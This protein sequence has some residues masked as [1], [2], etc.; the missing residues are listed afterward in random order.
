MIQLAVSLDRPNRTFLQGERITGTVT[1][2]ASGVV[3]CEELVVEF[4]HHFS[5]RLG[6]GE[7]VE[8][9]T[10]LF[11]GTWAPGVHAYPFSLP[12]TAELPSYQGQL[13]T[14]TRTV[15]ARAVPAGGAPGEAIAVVWV[16]CSPRDNAWF[17]PREQ[18]PPP[19]LFVLN[20]AP[21]R[22]LALKRTMEAVAGATL[23]G[24][25]PVAI[26]ISSRVLRGGDTVTITV[27]V[28]GPAGRLT[29]LRARLRGVE[30]WPRDHGAKSRVVHSEEYAPT[31]NS[32]GEITTLRF[33]LPVP[34]DAISIAAL[35]Q[36]RIQLR[37]AYG[38]LDNRD[39]WQPLWI[40]PSE[41]SLARLRGRS[42]EE[43]AVVITDTAEQL[44][45][46][47]AGQRWRAV[48]A[49]L[50]LVVSVGIP[51]GVISFGESG[52]FRPGALGVLAGIAAVIGW[53]VWKKR[54]VDRDFRDR[55]YR[56]GAGDNPASAEIAP[57]P[58]PLV[59]DLIKLGESH[60]SPGGDDVLRREVVATQQR[61]RRR[62]A[63]GLSFLLGVNLVAALI[64]ESPPLASGLAVPLTALSVLVL[65]ASV[66]RS[67]D[68]RPL[69][70]YVGM[71]P[72]LVLCWLVVSVAGAMLTGT[73]GILGRS[74]RD[75][76]AALLLLVGAVG[77]VFAARR[78]RPSTDGGRRLLVLW[79]FGATSRMEEIMREVALQW[80]YLGPIQYLRG[81]GSRADLGRLV[82]AL[83]RGGRELFADSLPEVMAHLRRFRFTPNI[84]GIYS[85][86]SLQC[87]NAVWRDAVD[88]L[89]D[90]TD[91]VLMD[92]T[93]FGEKNQ[94]C[95]YE[96]GVLI[97]RIPTSRLVLVVDGS[98]DIVLLGAQLQRLWNTMPVASPNR[99]AGA[100]PIRLFRI[101]LRGAE[102]PGR[103]WTIAPMNELV[104]LLFEPVA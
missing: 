94:G 70:C 27:A 98:T 8:T 102:T 103:H 83:R 49:A 18:Q 13:F 59:I 22:L 26:E 88:A 11:K 96:L 57:P 69:S 12:V 43:M 35:V 28:H 62:G 21:I 30:A 72:V 20:E 79:V 9:S 34:D 100:G 97:A 33:D 78:D 7:G 23:L 4:G 24:R 71:A 17:D 51:V 38:C 5:G 44:R 46:A 66:L 52:Q 36:W 61:V 10:I 39:R 58:A 32:D 75:G 90:T 99:A 80:V 42:T 37:G 15:R 55:Q 84:F 48:L 63:L 53:G 95:A 73:G 77:L 85:I 25:R 64:A 14:V 74:P 93:T 101:P 60:A 104:R 89:V 86:N 81:P 16:A 87:T 2:S 29:T 19:V 56:R 45:A 6:R 67:P 92:L 31:I 82:A 50:L 40:G 76:A 91:L 3:D 68:G 54:S 1:V 65:L 47:A 41:A